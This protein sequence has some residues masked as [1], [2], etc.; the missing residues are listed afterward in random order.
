M[1]SLPVT[2]SDDG[3]NVVGLKFD[4]VSVPLIVA[5]PAT[6]RFPP[7][8]RPNAE[9]LLPEPVDETSAGRITSGYVIVPVIPGPE[10]WIM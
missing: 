9:M 8:V 5:L 10:I 2:L 3:E 4:I 6:L 7:S 1:V